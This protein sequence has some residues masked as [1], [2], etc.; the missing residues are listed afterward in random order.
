MRRFECLYPLALRDFI[1]EQLGISKKKAKELIDNKQVFV[2]K[3]LVWIASHQLRRGDRVEI[4]EDQQKK[5]DP[6]LLLWENDEIIAVNKPAGM[7]VNED[8]NSL[9]AQ[10]RRFY[11]N[12]NIQ[13]I[14]RLDKDTSGIVLYAKK[15]NSLR[16]LPQKLG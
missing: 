7:V 6:S 11:H 3:Q 9:E 14:H 16:L 8:S 2:N 5:F 12:P 1:A 10:L 13:A 15:R 4:L